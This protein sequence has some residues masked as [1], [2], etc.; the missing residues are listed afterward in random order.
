MKKEEGRTGYVLRGVAVWLILTAGAAR[1]AAAN[2]V[3]ELPEGATAREATATAASMKLSTAGRIDGRMVRFEKLLPDTPYDIHIRLADGTTLAG[4]DLSW[5]SPDPPK[6]DSGELDEDDRGQIR[7]LV[8]D[9]RQFYDRAE[10]LQLVGDHDRAV[11]LV[12]QIRDSA[13]HGDKGGEVIWRIEVWY[14]ANRAGGWERIA[15]TNKVL[16]R[17]R[18]KDRAAYQAEIA[19]LSWIPRLGGVRIAAD[20]DRVIKWPPPAP[21]SATQPAGASSDAATPGTRPAGRRP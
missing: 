6:A 5:Y 8:Q 19:K 15:Q 11:A 16:R 21:R 4:V 17:E 18:F 2:L 3:V 1:L 14:F 9:V 7:A 20:E 13:F 10:I 12:Q